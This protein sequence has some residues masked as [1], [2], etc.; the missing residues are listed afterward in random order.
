MVMKSTQCLVLVTVRVYSIIFDKLIISAKWYISFLDNVSALWTLFACQK[1]LICS[2]MYF[3]HFLHASKYW[4]KVAFAHC[5]RFYGDLQL[6]KFKPT[7]LSLMKSYLIW[8]HTISLFLW[9]ILLV[10]CQLR[11]MIQSKIDTKTRSEEKQGPDHLLLQY[12]GLC[13]L[14]LIYNCLKCRRHVYWFDCIKSQWNWC[15]G[16]LWNEKCHMP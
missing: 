2:T 3:D 10:N 13:L 14:N 16:G 8:N 9:C 5:R 4:K 12:G 1:W 15:F 11:I 7:G 6:L